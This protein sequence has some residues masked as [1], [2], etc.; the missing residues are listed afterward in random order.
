MELAVYCPS[1]CHCFRYN[2]RF[3]GR[4][5]D[6]RSLQVSMPELSRCR[7][8]GHHGGKEIGSKGFSGPGCCERIPSGPGKDH[9]LRQR[10][11]AGVQRQAHG[12]ANL[13]FGYLCQGNE[14]SICNSAV[15]ILET[16]DQGIAVAPRLVTGSSPMHLCFM[17]GRSP[18]QASWKGVRR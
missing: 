7:W 1:I 8:Q 6:A 5:E 13:R 16:D 2:H 14:I 9:Q 17:S 3:R 12:R 10:Q 4:P 18:S 15:L 11:D